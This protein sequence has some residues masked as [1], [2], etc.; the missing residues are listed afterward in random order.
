MKPV[1]TKDFCISVRRQSWEEDGNVAE[2]FSDIFDVTLNFSVT[3]YFIPQIDKQYWP[4]LLPNNFN[5]IKSRQEARS[6][7]AALAKYIVTPNDEKSGKEEVISILSD[8]TNLVVFYV[9]ASEFDI[10]SE[11][12][13]MLSDKRPSV[14][15]GWK[16]SEVL[17][18]AV[19]SYIKNVFL[20][21]QYIDKSDLAMLGKSNKSDLQE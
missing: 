18:L 15:S 8:D 6:G 10:F 9:K 2:Y 1:P 19:Y 20:N 17:H 3:I 7:T 14:H 13:C 5:E 11:E 4:P 16:I 21:S 12:L